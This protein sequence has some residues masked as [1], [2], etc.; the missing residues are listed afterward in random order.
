MNFETRPIEE[1]PARG[2]G[3]GYVKTG[4]TVAFGE[5]PADLALLIPSLGRKL[6]NVQSSS[7]TYLARR[8]P[9]RQ[10]RTRIDREKDGIWFWWE[11]KTPN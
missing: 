3:G 10:I 11:P 8:Y 1:L 5:L 7:A 9:D 4:L 2:P 6:N